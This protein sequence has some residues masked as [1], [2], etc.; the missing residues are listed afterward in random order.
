[1]KTLDVKFNGEDYKIRRNMYTLNLF[2]KEYKKL[3]D[4]ADQSESLILFSWS[5]L[6]GYNKGFNLD[7]EDVAMHIDEPD[8]EDFLKSISEILNPEEE[9]EESDGEKK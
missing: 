7:I 6:K 9:G 2:Q 4:D 1:M 3:G 8:N 5:A